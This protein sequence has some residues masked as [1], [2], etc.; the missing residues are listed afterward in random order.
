MR[1]ESLEFLKQLLSAPTPSG[2]ESP[3]QKVWCQYARQYAD[4]V[5]TDAYG[6]AVAVLNAGGDPKIM[7]DGHADELGMMVK[8]IDE[9]GFISVQRIGGVDPALVRGK[10]VNIHTNKG[11]VKGVVGATAIHLLP[12]EGEKKVPKWPELFVD[13]GASDGKEAKKKVRVGDVITFAYDFEMLNKNVSVARAFDNRVGT[14]CAI[15]GLR[16]AKAHVGKGKQLNCAIYACSSVQEEVGGAGA[17][18]NVA[19]VKPDAAVVVDVTHATDSPGIDVK[20]HGEVKMGEGPT[21]SIGRENHPVLSEHVVAAAKA[22]KIPLQFEAFSISGGTN[23]LSIYTKNGGVPSVVLSLPNRYM[24]TT[25]EM[26]DMRDL[27]RIAELLAAV[28]LRTK[29]GERFKVKVF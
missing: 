29:R 1:T 9:K 23:A 16:L 6:N 22:E 28:A 12:R 2:F 27:Q 15:E 13:I 14:W 3:G 17:A 8:Y 20:E 4:E 5:H 25:V 24:H 26:I 21:L 11:I 19:N 18:M 7:F 10:R